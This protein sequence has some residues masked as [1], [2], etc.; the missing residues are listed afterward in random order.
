MSLNFR[1]DAL[2]RP[3]MGGE[4]QGRGLCPRLKRLETCRLNLGELRLESLVF[5]LLL[6]SSRSVGDVAYFKGILRQIVHLPLT[7]CDIMHVAVLSQF[8][9]LL[10][11][12]GDMVRWPWI[13]TMCLTRLIVVI[14]EDNVILDWRSQ[15]IENKTRIINSLPRCAN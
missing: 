8:E 5:S 2:P 10:T 13:G 4:I 6:P 3:R 12:T 7:W 1:R 15:R 14:G 9:S 11:D